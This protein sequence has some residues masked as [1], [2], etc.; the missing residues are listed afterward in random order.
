MQVFI[1]IFIA[2]SIAA[3]FII[4]RPKLY[5]VQSVLDGDTVIVKRASRRTTIRLAS[6]DCPESDQEWG[7]IATAGLVKLIG[8]KRIRV[9]PHTWDQYGRTIATI[10]VLDRNK[11][12]WVNVNRRM[13]MLGHAWVYRRYLD[14]LP[15]H[16]IN[17]LFQLESW[18]RRKRVGLWRR[19]RPLPPWVF[20][21]R[22]RLAGTESLVRRIA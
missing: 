9:E 1:A 3:L 15:Q 4:S 10:H 20:R 8:G 5:R 11:G 17:E 19:E 7:D 22:S 14:H 6:I 12:E 18:A 21:Q 2:A 16:Q 13:V